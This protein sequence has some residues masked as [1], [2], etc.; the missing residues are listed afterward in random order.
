MPTQDTMKQFFAAQPR[1]L[2]RRHGLVPTILTQRATKQSGAQLHTY[3]HNNFMHFRLRRLSRGCSKR[4]GH[5]TCGRYTVHSKARTHKGI[6]LTQARKLITTAILGYTLMPARVHRSLK[7][8]VPYI[9]G[10]GNILNVPCTS[11]YRP[12]CYFIGAGTRLLALFAG[13]R[14]VH[15][16]YYMLPL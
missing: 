9:C 3:I 15:N 4:T 7:L 14:A 12:L 8:V 16:I 1:L 5:T 11:R 2:R 6:Q 13:A 10:D